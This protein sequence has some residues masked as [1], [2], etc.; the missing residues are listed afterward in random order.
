[1]HGFRVNQLYDVF[2]T[3]KKT[4]LIYDVL[5]LDNSVTDN[6]VRTA[7]GTKRPFIHPAWC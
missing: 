4:L 5:S 1:M 6:H 7:D 3:Q 2:S